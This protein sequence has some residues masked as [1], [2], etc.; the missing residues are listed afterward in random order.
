MIILFQRL[1]VLALVIV[2]LLLFTQF[3]TTLDMTSTTYTII[4]AGLI[5]ALLAAFYG[6]A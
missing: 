2:A 1:M 3:R 4:G 5:P 6:N